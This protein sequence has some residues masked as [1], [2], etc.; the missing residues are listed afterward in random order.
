[1]CNLQVCKLSNETSNVAPDLA[2]LRRRDLE[3]RINSKRYERNLVGPEIR[4]SNY[5]PQPQQCTT[6]EGRARDNGDASASACASES[7]AV[8]CSRPPESSVLSIPRW[9][10]G[11]PASLANGGRLETEKRLCSNSKPWRGTH[12]NRLVLSTSRIAD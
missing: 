1:M 9:R 7:S 11:I 5:H 4:P 2:T 8:G 12:D 10:T 3:G 6:E